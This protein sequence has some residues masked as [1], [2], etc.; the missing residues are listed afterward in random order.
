MDGV[1]SLEHRFGA[2]SCGPAHGIFSWSREVRRGVMAELPRWEGHFRKVRVPRLDGGNTGAKC[3]LQCL[4]GHRGGDARWLGGKLPHQKNQ[5]C[6]RR[7]IHVV[8]GTLNN[9]SLD[10]GL[11]TL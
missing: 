4:R 5:D 8:S 1:I 6:I 9:V 3:L 11:G 7:I 2:W 10:N